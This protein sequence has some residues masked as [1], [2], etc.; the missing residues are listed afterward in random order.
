MDSFHS[1]NK[2]SEAISFEE[3][4]AGVPG[5]NHV[6]KLKLASERRGFFSFLDFI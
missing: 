5:Y 4:W 3:K 6:E 1:K 2:R